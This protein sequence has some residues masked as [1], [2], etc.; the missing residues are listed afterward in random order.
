[1]QSSWY[2]RIFPRTI[3][4]ASRTVVADFETVGGGGRLATL[5]SGTLTGRGGDI[6]SFPPIADVP[7]R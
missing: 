6:I 1:M 4:K 5:I 3:I 2:R 7:Q